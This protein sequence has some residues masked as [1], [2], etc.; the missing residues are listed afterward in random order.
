MLPLRAIWGLS[1][2]TRPRNLGPN[3]TQLPSGSC[4]VSVPITPRTWWRHQGGPSQRT[5][6]TATRLGGCHSA[7]QVSFLSK[8]QGQVLQP[9]VPNRELQTH[10][11][12]QVQLTPTLTEVPRR[13]SRLVTQFSPQGR[14]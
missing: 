1:E 8:V 13:A 2:A 3:V 7:H 5:D 6:L 4:Y 14:G 9:Q 10:R 12:A 11:R